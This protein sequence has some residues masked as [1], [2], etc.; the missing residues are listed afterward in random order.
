MKT[1]ILT[2]TIVSSFF[3]FHSSFGQGALTPPGA[4]APTMKSLDQIE[5]RT[6]ISSAPFTITNPGSYYL[7]TNITVSSGNAITI[8]TNG[9]TLD[10]NGFNISSTEASPTGTGIL[11]GS[12]L[13]D[14]TILNGHIKG[15][16]TYSSGNYT[17]SG[18]ANGIY[19]SGSA[20]LNVRVTGV[21]VSGC[22]DNGIALG[23]VNSTIVESCTVLTV[24]GYGIEA[25]TVVRSYAKNCGNVAI[26]ADTVSDSEG[27]CTGS[28]DGLDA[29]FSA[30]NC[31]G[32]STSG[33]GLNAAGT[34]NNCYGV[35]LVGDGL[36][37]GTATG[38]YGTSYGGGFGVLTSF[39]AENCYG[40][41][42]SGDGVAT[43]T[44]LNCC[45]TSDSGYGIIAKTAQNC[46]G[47][48]TSGTGLYANAAQNCYGFNGGSYTGLQALVAQNCYGFSE[49]G[50]GLIADIANV[51]LGD[52][53]TGTATNITHNVNSY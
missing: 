8:A 11:L 17:G 52:T 30:N 16:V 4:P 48:N 3:I 15:R 22:L 29:S 1:K 2:A 50:V 18:F 25:S 41:S 5:P 38:C 42:G 12:A 44:A 37:S 26:S 49:N 46:Y 6:P 7:T 24:G 21:S 40:S 36:D 51:C 32:V 45:G 33:T 34:A 53:S 13:T 23:T 9:V 31:T 47:T 28:S 27:D 14:I 43:S 39:S 19:I 10:L 20:V 35:S